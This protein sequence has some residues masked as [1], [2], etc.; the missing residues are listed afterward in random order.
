[1][2]VD[3]ANGSTAQSIGFRR[4]DIIVSVNNRH[5][6]NTHE[7]ARIADEQLRTWRVIIRRGG[8]QISAVFN[9]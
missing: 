3:V 5:I 1:V 9:G 6:D 2:V 4:G 8:R 7:L